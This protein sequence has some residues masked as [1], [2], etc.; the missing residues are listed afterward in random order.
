MYL[1]DCYLLQV[2][3]VKAHVPIAAVAEGFIKPTVPRPNIAQAVALV[4]SLIMPHNIYLVSCLSGILRLLSNLVGCC[5]DSVVLSLESDTCR[6]IIV[7]CCVCMLGTLFTTLGSGVE[8][9]RSCYCVIIIR[10]H[11]A[12]KTLPLVRNRQYSS[13]RIDMPPEHPFAAASH[14]HTPSLTLLQFMVI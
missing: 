14:V 3:F 1:V 9:L 4:G 7:W 13:T 10:R 11:I 5:A 8:T 2:M 6:H 12:F